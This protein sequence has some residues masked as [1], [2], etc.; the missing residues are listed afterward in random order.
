MN[1][2]AS[3]KQGLSVRD[4]CLIGLMVAIIEVSKVALSGL[5]NIELTSFWLILFAIHMDK[6]VYY[7]VP[8]FILLE[9]LIYGM[10]IWWI[11]YLYSWPLLVFLARLLR[12]MESPLSWAILSGAFGLSFGALCAIPYLFIGAAGATLMDGL[13]YAISWWIAGIPW[14]LTHDIGN[15]VIML[16]LY[17]PVSKAMIAMKPYLKA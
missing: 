15:F 1:T 8:V 13:R 7:T 9:G 5:P 12:K 3:R 11:M 4:I 14:D 6:R 10:Q 2:E 17:K 16:A